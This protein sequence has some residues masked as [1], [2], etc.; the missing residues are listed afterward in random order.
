MV[1]M[2]ICGPNVVQCF[3]DVLVESKHYGYIETHP[4]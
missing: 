3:H 2:L 4:S 1:I